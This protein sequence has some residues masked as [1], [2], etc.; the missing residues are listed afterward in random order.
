MD[1]IACLGL[2]IL[3]GIIFGC[4]G[5][6]LG[7]GL[8]KLECCFWLHLKYRYLKKIGFDRSDDHGIMIKDKF[9]GDFTN[10][11]VVLEEK[12]VR[13]LSYSSLKKYIEW[14]TWE[15]E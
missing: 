6:V 2:S 8:Y 11:N 10:G 13:S 4:I 12:T 9:Y 15:E 7:T 3:R 5:F 14:R 1:I